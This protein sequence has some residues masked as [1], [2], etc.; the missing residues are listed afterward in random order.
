MGGLSLQKELGPL[1]L[2][3]DP[4]THVRPHVLFGGLKPRAKEPDLLEGAREQSLPIGTKTLQAGNRGVFF[5]SQTTYVAL[6]PT[7]EAGRS[8][9][10]LNPF[11]SV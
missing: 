9:C 5:A 6:K 10:D 2:P 11:Y 3:I 7:S 8:Q 1:G 4:P